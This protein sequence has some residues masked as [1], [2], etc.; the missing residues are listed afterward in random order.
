MP[1][2]TKSSRFMMLLNDN[3]W[4]KIFFFIF[5]ASFFAV[6]STSILLWN[7]LWEFTYFFF[8]IYYYQLVWERG[9]ILNKDLNY[10]LKLNYKTEIIK[11]EK[12]GG[13]AIS[14]PEL[15]GFITC[16]DTIENGM[17]MLEDA[18]KCWLQSCLEDNIPIPEPNN[19]REYSGQFKLR[20]PKSLHKLLA[21]HSRNEGISMNQYCL[22]LLSKNGL[23]NN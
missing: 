1:F 21:E 22:Y 18:K 10:Y 3:Y 19:F 6:K 13:F 17:E 2:F 15:P 12:E 5:G 14:C 7:L 20:I 8:I 9:F 4:L 23:Q 11:D 16:F